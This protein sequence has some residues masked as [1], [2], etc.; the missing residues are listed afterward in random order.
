MITNEDKILYA[1]LQDEKTRRRAFEDIVSRYGEKIYWQIRRMVTNHDDANDVLQETFLKAWS[2][3]TS[4]R[5]D[6][7]IT[8]WLYRIA[9]NESV[10]FLSKQRHTESIDIGIRED[11]ESE[12]VGRNPIETLESDTYFDGDET[13]L[14]LHSAISTLPEKQRAVFNM[15]YFDNMKYEEI[16]RITGT[17]LGALKASYHHAV[18]KITKFFNM[19]E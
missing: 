10:N 12:L 17:S 8:T 7:N 11:D 13:E 5:A 15:R 6:S 4:F 2:N 14:L 16:S 19:H 9:Y 3:I 18:E 1:K